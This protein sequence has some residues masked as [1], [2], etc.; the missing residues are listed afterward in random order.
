MQNK[1][2]E[3][4]LLGVS[5]YGERHLTVED[6]DSINSMIG[7]TVSESVLKSDIDGKEMIEMTD[8]EDTHIMFLDLE[9]IQDELGFD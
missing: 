7:D 1:S 9:Y 6:I 2:K 3:Y 8:G 4:K 5:D